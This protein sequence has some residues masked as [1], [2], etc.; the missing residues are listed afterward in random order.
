[1]LTVAADYRIAPRDVFSELVPT[2]MNFALLVQPDTSET[3]S[4]MSGLS[5]AAASIG[6]HVEVF[7]AGRIDE[8]DTAFAAL[9]RKGADALIVGSS[10]MLNT[11]R[12]QLATLAAYYH[13]Q[14]CF[15]IAER[16]RSAG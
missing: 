11:R 6:R 7:N 8:I 12:T 14:P 3:K 4:I 1:L 10:S 15:T 13:L 16:S 9:V 5:T 2:A